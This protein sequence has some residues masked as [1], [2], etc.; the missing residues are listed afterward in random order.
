MGIGGRPYTCERAN[1]VGVGCGE[2]NL[3]K[4]NKWAQIGNKY[5]E[6]TEK[7]SPSPIRYAYKTTKKK[8]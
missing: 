8:D 2:C 6:T 5:V 3:E 4:K 1:S 7:S